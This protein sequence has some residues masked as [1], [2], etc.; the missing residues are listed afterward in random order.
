LNDDI[1]DHSEAKPPT[2][3]ENQLISLLRQLAEFTECNPAWSRAVNDV[4]IGQIMFV[5]IVE[6]LNGVLHR[7]Q[8]RDANAAAADRAAARSEK[9]AKARETESSDG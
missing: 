1:P 7:L 8:S 4:D 6:T 9:I 3:A 2:L 5:G